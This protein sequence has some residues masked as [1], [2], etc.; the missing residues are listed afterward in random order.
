MSYT[1]RLTPRA[2]LTMRVPSVLAS[3]PA[4]ERVRMYE[5]PSLEIAGWI[6]VASIA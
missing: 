2:S 3:D 1:T 6:R 4:P 5:V